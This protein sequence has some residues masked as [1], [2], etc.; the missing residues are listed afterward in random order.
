MSTSSLQARPRKSEKIAWIIVVLI[1]LLFLIFELAGRY[2]L[3][4]THGLLLLLILALVLLVLLREKP[5]WNAHD[6]IEHVRRER[7]KYNQE[8]LNPLIAE[9]QPAG[10][11]L[12]VDFV[13]NALAFTVDPIRK[14]TIGIRVKTADE[15]LKQ[16][17]RSETLKNAFNQEIKQQKTEEALSALGYDTDDLEQTEEES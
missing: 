14:C 11:N 10:K 15:I 1:S 13:G 17:E 5:P 12:I 6:A 2:H 9:V 16:I 3:N 7:L 4:P 8:Y